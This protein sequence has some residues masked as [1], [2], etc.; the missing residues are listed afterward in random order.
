MERTGGGVIVNIAS[1]VVFSAQTQRVSYCG[2][3]GAVVGLARS[4]ALAVAAMGI[5]VNCVCPGNVDTLMFREAVR[6]QH[7]GEVTDMETVVAEIGN[8][9][10][11]GRVAAP[12]E[13][14]SVVLFLATD[15]SFQITGQAILPDGGVTLT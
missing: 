6:A 3:K 11:V 8:T 7:G 14:P 10:P 12:E 9:L 4:L 15:G 5:R 2:T 1:A 13:I